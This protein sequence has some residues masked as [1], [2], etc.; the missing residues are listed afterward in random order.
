[1]FLVIFLWFVVL[2]ISIFLLCINLPPINQFNSMVNAA[3]RPL[4]DQQLFYTGVTFKQIYLVQTNSPEI[5]LRSVPSSSSK[6]MFRLSE[7]YFP[8]VTLKYNNSS[9]VLQKNMYRNGS[10]ICLALFGEL[11]SYN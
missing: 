9:G 6:R 5:C 11:I 10:L 4:C 1:M 8:S 3:K 7:G 2:W